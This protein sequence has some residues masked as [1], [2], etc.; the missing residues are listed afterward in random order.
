[1]NY[2]VIDGYYYFIDMS[3]YRNDSD[4]RSRSSVEDGDA[5]TYRRNGDRVLA[6][7]H[8]A[9]SPEAY[10]EYCLSAFADSPVLFFMIEGLEVPDISC[11]PSLTPLHMVFDLS[12]K[13]DLRV[14]YLDIRRMTYGFYPNNTSPVNW[15]GKTG[16]PFGTVTEF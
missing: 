12:V 2:F 7:I 5:E 8:K 6:N 11:D 16:H 13:D 3:H 15:E 14:I 4:S 1:M 10:V 9:V